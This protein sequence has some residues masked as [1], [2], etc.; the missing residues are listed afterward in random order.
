MT[1]KRLEDCVRDDLY[2]A[3]FENEYEV[4]IMTAEELTSD[5]MSCSGEGYKDE[6]YLEVLAIVKEFKGEIQK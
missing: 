3:V 5:L 6:D 1:D 4:V 2:N